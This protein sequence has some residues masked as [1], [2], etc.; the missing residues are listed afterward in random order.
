MK[1]AE[2]QMQESVL[3]I[4]IV[5]IVIG[6]ALFVFYELQLK[7]I[8]N[9]KLELQKN[10]DLTLL[11]TLQ[12]FPELSYSY[13]GKEENA[14]DTLKLLT[15]KLENKGYKQITIKQIYPEVQDKICTKLNYPNCNSYVIYNKTLKKI[16]NT[17]ILSLPVS[18]YYPHSNKYN[19]GLIEIRS[20]S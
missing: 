10:R 19:S 6:M 11:S 16:K 2:M 18:L 20:F 4:F 7:S 15:T 12:N 1:K 3:V 8:E 17:E 5:T 9:S 14:L 13:L